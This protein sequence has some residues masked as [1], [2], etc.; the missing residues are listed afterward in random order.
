M[1]TEARASPVF[2]QPPHVQQPSATNDVFPRPNNPAF[3]K[4]RRDPGN[5]R[6]LLNEAYLF[7]KN[8]CL[9]E[10]GLLCFVCTLCDSTYLERQRR[11]DR[12]AFYGC[13]NYGAGCRGGV[14]IRSDVAAREY[15]VPGVI[16]N[17]LL[18]TFFQEE[19]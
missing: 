6:I 1:K 14:T 17:V 2:N 9:A 18:H 8:F 4:I 19:K 16:G 5:H 12:Q 7:T 3:P 11:A 13:S 10:T 15:G